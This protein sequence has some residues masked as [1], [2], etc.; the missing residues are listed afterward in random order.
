MQ[1]AQ[2]QAALAELDKLVGD[3]NACLRRIE[4]SDAKLA[5]NI[6]KPLHDARDLE[7]VSQ[8]S[9]EFIA[10]ASQAIQLYNRIKS[11]PLFAGNYRETTMLSRSAKDRLSE[12]KGAASV[13]AAATLRYIERR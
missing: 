13:R 12:A 1:P 2:N 6:Q 9:N 10:A 4:D 11:G 8:E 5:M 7:I 3:Y